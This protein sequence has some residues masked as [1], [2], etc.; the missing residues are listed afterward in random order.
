MKVKRIVA[1]IAAPDPA[2][3]KQFYQDIL[4]P[5]LCPRSVRQAGQH[6]DARRGLE[7]RP[8]SWPES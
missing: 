8:H 7:T 5:I 1:D 6:S 4:A 2:A 3:A